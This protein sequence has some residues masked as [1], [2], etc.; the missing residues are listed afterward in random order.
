MIQYH[1]PRL[2]SLN[3]YMDIARLP[4]LRSNTN[5]PWFYRVPLPNDRTCTSQAIQKCPL[6]PMYLGFTEC[7]I[8]GLVILL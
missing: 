2:C 3:M 7:V 8:A 1:L 5:A 4:E 6:C